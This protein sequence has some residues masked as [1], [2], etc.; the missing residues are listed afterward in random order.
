[1]QAARSGADWLVSVNVDADLGADLTIL[2]SSPGKALS[3]SDF[4]L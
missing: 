1:V 3:E 4:V 2:L